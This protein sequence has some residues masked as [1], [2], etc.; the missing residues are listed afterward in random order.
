MAT[1]P[2]E[3]LS[4]AGMEAGMCGIAGFIGQGEPARFS[5]RADWKTVSTIPLQSLAH[6][7]PDD[8]GW[9]AH[10]PHAGVSLATAE[11]PVANA[12]GSC[13]LLLHRRL[14]ILD[15]TA[16]GHQ[17]MRSAAGAHTIVFNGEIYNY[18]ELREELI[19]L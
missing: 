9:V 3:K 8:S 4:E 2:E 18:R 6:R 17:P 19:K 1:R 14:S 15:V 13:L 7:G 11:F 10:R 5:G 16:A 12:S